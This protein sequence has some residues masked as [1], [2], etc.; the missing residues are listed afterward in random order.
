MPVTAVRYENSIGKVITPG[1]HAG[2]VIAVSQ[3]DDRGRVGYFYGTYMV[4][5]IWTNDG[6]VERINVD[7]SGENV[8][9]LTEENRQE[10]LQA[11][12]EAVFAY[13]KAKAILTSTEVAKRI[14]RGNRVE[15]IRGRKV[16]RG[17]TGS[18]VGFT[19]PN[20]FGIVKVG[21]ATSDRTEKVTFGRKEYDRHLDVVWVDQKNVEKIDWRLEMC[22]D[23]DCEKDAI[24]FANEVVTM[25]DKE[26]EAGRYSK[27]APYNPMFPDHIRIYR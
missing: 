15:V 16:A 13:K 22:S 10:Y 8:A 1:Q 9:D 17:T 2:R 21:I 24:D 23:E 11:I 3:M 5:Y 26:M 25:I 7:E 6:K 20:S 19:Q 18:V 27:R 4:A 12:W 14:Q